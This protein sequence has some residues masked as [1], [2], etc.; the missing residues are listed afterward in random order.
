MTTID[1]LR[2]GEAAPGICLGCEFDAPLTPAGWTQM[3]N[4]LSWVQPPWDGVVSS[5]SQRCAA[6]AEELVALQGLPL[7]YDPRLRE[8][9]F[10]AWEGKRWADLYSY[11]QEG[12]RLME[13]QRSPRFNPA[14]DGE[15]YHDFESRIAEAWN[16]LSEMAHDRHWLLITHAGV[17]R[18]VLRLVLGFPVERLFSV[19]VPYAGLT[20]IERRGDHPARLVFHGGKL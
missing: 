14:P 1:L 16:E 2:H 9:G 11:S 7:R 3:R 5:P 4:V 18:S 6:F 10:G 12:E 13:F 17:V 19:Y 8:L 15:H 20:R